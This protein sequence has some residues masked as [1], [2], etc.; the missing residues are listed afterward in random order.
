MQISNFN[1]TI[2]ANII[3]VETTWWFGY[4]FWWIYVISMTSKKCSMHKIY[5]RSRNSN[6]PDFIISHIFVMK[7]RPIFLPDEKY[8]HLRITKMY[9][10]AF[11]VIPRNRDLNSRKILLNQHYTLSNSIKNT[12][13]I[14]L[15]YSAFRSIKREHSNHLC[16]T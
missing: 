6:S 5:H 7:I 14:C 1:C 12:I 9:Q 16:M 10:I 15:H 2:Y 13:W 11:M 3:F 8:F 4:H